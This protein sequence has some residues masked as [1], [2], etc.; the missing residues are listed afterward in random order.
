M[1]GW[2]DFFN[3][4]ELIFGSIHKLYIYSRPELI[5]LSHKKQSQQQQHTSSPS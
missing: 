4:I 3:S 1:D 2:M 5:T